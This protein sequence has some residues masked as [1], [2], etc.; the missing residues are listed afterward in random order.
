MNEHKK[1]IRSQRQITDSVMAAMKNAEK[2][3]DVSC[4]LLLHNA[5]R[6]RLSPIKLHHIFK[7]RN[8]R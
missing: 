1:S 7:G 8:D 4:H 2:H 3:N 6:L 5:L